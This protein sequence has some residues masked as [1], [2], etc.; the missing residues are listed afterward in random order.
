M[1]TANQKVEILKL[2]TKQIQSLNFPKEEYDYNCYELEYYQ[3]MKTELEQKLYWKA[4]KI[5]D[6]NYEPF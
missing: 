1:I 6:P 3:F 2:I 5:L 4:N